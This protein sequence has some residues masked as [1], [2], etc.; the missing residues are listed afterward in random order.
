MPEDFQ[1]IGAG[2]LPEVGPNTGYNNLTLLLGLLAVAF[3][4]CS[5]IRVPPHRPRHSAP[6]SPMWVIDPRLVLICGAIVFATCLLR[7]RPGRAPAFPIS[8]LILAV[9][10]ILY[11]FFTRN[12]AAAGTST[13]SAATARRRAVRR[14]APSRSTSSS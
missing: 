13:R 9:L 1:Y 10:V 4:V 14:Q 7:R 2:Y 11:A 12:T 3:V 8:G 6:T 5:E